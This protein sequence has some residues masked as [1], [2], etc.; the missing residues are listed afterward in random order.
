MFKNTTMFNQYSKC[1][2]KKTTMTYSNALCC[3]DE[4]FPRVSSEITY[5]DNIIVCKIS[6]CMTTTA[7]QI[8]IN[9]SYMK[10]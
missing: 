8:S 5:Y 10:F 7:V 9:F 6:I 2:K 1:L 3:I 4:R